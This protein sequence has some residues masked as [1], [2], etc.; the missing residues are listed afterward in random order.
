MTQQPRRH[1]AVTHQPRKDKAQAET[2]DAKADDYKPKY[3]FLNNHSV[4]FVARRVSQTSVCAPAIIP[5]SPAKIS[6]S[7]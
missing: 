2:A 7:E 6:P 1:F 4:A 3:A 5:A